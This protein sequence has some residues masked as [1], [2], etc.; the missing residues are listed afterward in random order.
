MELLGPMKLEEY[1][2]HKFFVEYV[3]TVPSGN[4]LR[5]HTSNGQVHNLTIGYAESIERARQEVI[6]AFK[7]H[8]DGGDFQ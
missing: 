5:V 7:K 2:G 6:D 8:L 1:A 4:W 3:S